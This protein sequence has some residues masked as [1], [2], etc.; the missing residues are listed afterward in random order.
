MRISVVVIVFNLDA[1]IGQA[2]DSV[3]CQTRKAD[4]VIVVDDCSTDQSA[5]RVK[6]YGDK[7]RYLRMP[8]NC[9]ALL[10]AL[11]GVKAASG[12]IVCMLDGDDYWLPSNEGRRTRIPSRPRPDAPVS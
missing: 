2:I 11:H 12:D 9:G 7:V 6:A 10:T 3:L 4:E 8:K 5:E 1:Y